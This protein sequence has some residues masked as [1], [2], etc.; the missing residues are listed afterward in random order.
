[1]PTT[2]K[3]TSWMLHH[4]SCT[5]KALLLDRRK[6]I[7]NWTHQDLSILLH[8][9]SLTWSYWNRF[10]AAAPFKSNRTTE[11]MLEAQVVHQ[12][13]WS[14][15]V[16]IKNW[17]TKSKWT[18]RDRSPMEARAAIPVDQFQAHHK[19]KDI[20]SPSRAQAQVWQR[21]KELVSSKHRKCR[22]LIT[23]KKMT[24][25]KVQNPVP[26]KPRIQTRMWLGR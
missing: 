13:S 20:E 10:Q 12:D 23:E 7:N 19:T 4:I 5:W 14:I 9:S 15:T 24:K 22:P 17:K 25:N 11:E 2:S 26:I 6:M 21:G 16:R 18:L 3:T 1:M 8:I